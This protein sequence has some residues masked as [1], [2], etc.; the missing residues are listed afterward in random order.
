MH[1]CNAT[2]HISHKWLLWLVHTKQAHARTGMMFQVTKH[3]SLEQTV[4]PELRASTVYC[5]QTG[6]PG[7]VEDTSCLP[8]LQHSVPSS[9][10]KHVTRQHPQQADFGDDSEWVDGEASFAD[11][12]SKLQPIQE[13]HSGCSQQDAS[14]LAGDVRFAQ[15]FVRALFK[16]TGHQLKTKQHEGLGNG[17]S[18]G[19][20]LTRHCHACSRRTS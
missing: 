11:L 10:S 3:D 9:S 16:Q 17:T 15:P 12:S 6:I 8:S 7:E 5:Y 2:Q 14:D 1:L 18:A 20:S 4:S 13:E 19:V